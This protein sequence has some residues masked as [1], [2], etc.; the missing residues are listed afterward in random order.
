MDQ[1]ARLRVRVAVV[2]AAIGLLLVLVLLLAR[3]L[4]QN[5]VAWD[6][7]PPAVQ[8]Y[9]VAQLPEGF[10]VVQIEKGPTPR[11]KT[12]RVLV[13]G[14]GTRSQKL[15]LAADGSHWPPERSSS[16]VGGGSEPPPPTVATTER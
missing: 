15:W 2:C 12:Y 5:Q 11:Q 4:G 14:P 1:F 6:Q 3:Q 10:A 16:M 9:L 13:S 8:G 7:L